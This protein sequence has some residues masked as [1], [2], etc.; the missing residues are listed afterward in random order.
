M[1]VFSSYLA[2]SQDT[3]PKFSA[4]LLNKNMVQ[5]SWNNNFKNL[6][7]LTVQRSLDSITHFRSIF[8]SESPQ[9]P[10]NGFIDKK[11]P[12]GVKVYYRILYVFEGGAYFFTKSKQ[13]SIFNAET[14]IRTSPE[15]IS[16]KISAEIST[17]IIQ[18]IKITPEAIKIEKDKKMLGPKHYERVA[19]I[20]VKMQ[21]LQDLYIDGEMDK[22]EYEIVHEKNS[23]FIKEKLL[24]NISKSEFEITWDLDSSRLSM[25]LTS[26]LTG[27]LIKKGSVSF[28]G[29]FFSNKVTNNSVDLK[30]SFDLRLIKSG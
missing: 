1:I 13:P 25:L 24:N 27:K 23:E 26:I 2:Q 10:Q 5:I 9:L 17:P 11:N 7:Q 8:S 16:K 6:V 21:R 19:Q 14:L 22:K 12:I 15:L 29:N 20:E 3:L 30:Y 18:P 28:V 4:R